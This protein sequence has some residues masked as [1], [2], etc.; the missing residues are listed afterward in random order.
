MPGPVLDIEI[1]EIN[2]KDMG[3]VLKILMKRL[4]WGH[5]VSDSHSF[6]ASEKAS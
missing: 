2:S 3:P 5:T 6:G 1:K 4:E